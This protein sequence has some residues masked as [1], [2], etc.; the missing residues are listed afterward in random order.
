MRTIQA[1]DALETERP[2]STFVLT[3]EFHAAL[4]HLG[5]G[6]HLFLTGKAGTGKS[7][8]IRQ[9]ISQTDRNVI[10]VAPTG[11]AALNVDGYTIHRLFSFAPGTT[12]DQVRGDRYYPVRFAKALKALDVL[13]IDEASMV[14]ADLFDALEVALQRFG[15]RPGQPFGG[16]Q[17]VL[18]GDLF[19]LPP[20]VADGEGEYFVTR[21]ATPYFFSA[22]CFAINEF[23]V[24]HLT[25]VFRQ[26]GDSHLIDI[27]NAIREGS[28]DEGAR[29]VL[30]SRTLSGFD[31]PD[32]EFWLTLTTTN[33][34]ATARNRTALDR[35]PGEPHVSEASVTGDMDQADPP[36]DKR[37]EY[38]IGA[39]VMLLVNDPGDRFVNGTL[40][41]IV[42]IATD[43]GL[44][45]VTICTR[46]GGEVEVTPHTWEIT[47]PSVEGGRIRQE[48]VGTF[49]QL[50]FRLAWAITIHKSQGQTV[51]RLVV[52]LSG[53]TFAY[54]QLYVALSRCTSMEG[55]VLHRDVI[56]KDLKTDQRVRRFLADGRDPRAADPVYLGICSAGHSGSRTRPRPVEIAVV[57]EDGTGASTLINP[58]SDLY[59]S[60]SAYGICAGDVVAAPRL[61]EAWPALMPYLEGRVPVGVGIDRELEYIDFE[62]KRNGI[63]EPM[64]LGVSLPSDDLTAAERAGLQASTA[65]ER[66][67]ATREVA[68]RTRG[69]DPFASTFAS[70]TRPGYLL[71]RGRSVSDA[72]FAPTMTCD[73]RAA[74]VQTLRARGPRGAEDTNPI[75]VLVEGARVCF[76]GSVLDSLGRPL[77]RQEIEQI[78]SARGLI[79]V[80]TVTKTRCDVLVCAE[81]GTQ[82]GKTRKANELGKPVVLAEHFL[83]WAIG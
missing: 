29:A 32:R 30:N 82:S 5:E 16:V 50:P 27:L 33:R 8:L 26:A 64:P 63:V 51:D 19:Q 39:Q 68:R 58:E 74:L 60:R 55:L 57:I 34:I 44:P 46:G 65:L 52:D 75:A 70:S 56:P 2:A 4:K 47:R 62:L 15:P 73:E 42:R 14:R 41:T 17:I 35:L 7:T 45:I 43:E 18:V 54:G 72:I 37:L 40:G 76:T 31:P 9:F 69:T 12:A 11:I 78:A 23:R 67:L 6:S 1:A 28:I 66:A 80:G 36:N 25:R 49:R 24:A 48:V 71:P 20:V 61:A 83:A 79:P 77:S 22:D 53:G 59:D 21:Y 10:V 81:E 13:I 3:D 38:K